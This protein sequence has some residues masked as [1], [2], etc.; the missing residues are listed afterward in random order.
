MLAD[1]RYEG[2]KFGA[3]AA[4]VYVDAASV[5]VKPDVARAQ[6]ESE[7]PA[8]S[9]SEPE[10]STAPG[11]HPGPGDSD[12]GDNPYPPPRLP[13]RFLGSVDIDPDRAGRDMGQVAEEI[14]QHLTTLTGSKVKVTVEIEAH[15]TGGVSDDV[16]RVIEEICRTL[17][18]T[19]HG[20]EQD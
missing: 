19:E 3:R 1:S 16:R 9:P 20:L 12:P 7:R 5:L 18:F 4:A 14:L 15:I 13:R 10:P 6:I 2:L 8:P 17:R 11:E